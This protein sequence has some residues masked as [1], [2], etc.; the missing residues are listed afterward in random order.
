M[1]GKKIYTEK[2]FT[3]FQLSDRVPQ[4]NFY[5]RLKENV[6][7]DFISSD[8]KKYYGNC[9]QQSIDPVVFFKLMLVGYLEN[10]ITDRK[11]IE[12]CSMRM[13]ILFFLGYDIDEPLPW[14]STISRTRQLYET[15]LFESIFNKV[16]N[17]CVEKGMV[18]GHTQAIDS[19]FVKANA[20]MDSLEVK[21]P[22]QPLDKH[23]EELNLNNEQPYRKAKND[24]SSDEQRMLTASEQDLNE[25]QTRYEYQDKVNKDRP[26]SGDEKAKYYSNKTHYS[27]TDPDAKISVKPGK[28]RQLNY[29]CSMAVDT[30]NHVITHIQ[31]DLA[32]KKDSQYLIDIVNK[33]KQ[34]INDN[35]LELL[36]I[37]ADTGYSSGENYNILEKENINAWIP[38]H[39]QFKN[40]REGFIYNEKEDCY[41]CPNNKKVVCKKTFIDKE[42][43][44]L[45]R[46]ITT[47]KDCKECPFKATC[48]GKNHEK[49]FDITYYHKEYQR[50]YERQ[51]SRTGK[52]MKKKR[53]STVEPVFGTL[54]NFLGLRKIN[55]RGQAG[56]HKVMTMAAI[57]YNIKKL[58][59]FFSTKAIAHYK[60]IE[61]IKT[62]LFMIYIMRY[63]L[64]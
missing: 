31:A 22:A 21:Q 12:H 13:D 33:T 7:L 46:Y 9:G 39:G 23:I 10:I 3:S 2:L 24:K 63:E 51:H 60:A 16:F 56:A 5:R 32:D 4:D 61:L 36:N 14:H 38:V 20:S 40:E 64:R 18:S 34:R 50:A 44:K 29:M 58:L 54:I 37:A 27:P 41:I 28:P 8:T 11:L 49:K 52:Y 30:S 17:A 53:Q 59:K 26:G 47:R 42:G 45:K 15:S 43:R 25:L 35:H 48:I 6:N 57:A 19:A 55:V 62:D 1:Q